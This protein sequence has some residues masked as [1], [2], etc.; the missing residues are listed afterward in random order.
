[1]A[2]G[3]GI[4]LGMMLNPAMLISNAIGDITS[5]I[6]D[7]IKAA[8]EYDSTMK[9]LET[10]TGASAAEVDNMKT[11]VLA[12]APTVA[13]GPEALAK[14][15]YHIESAGIRGSQAIDIMTTAAKGAVVGQADLESVTNAMLAAV[16]SGIGGID[17]MSSAMGVLNAIVGAGNMR[18]ED[19]TAAMSTGILSVAKSF[20]V[21]LESVGGALAD[22]THQGTPAEE[23]ATRLRMTMS[24]MA[25]PTTKAAGALKSIGLNTTDLANAMRGPDGVLGAITML[26]AHLDA[27]GLSA[28]DAAALIVHAFG[29]GKSS[30]GILQLLG[31]VKMLGDTQDRVNKGVGDF[32]AAWAVASDEAT[33]KMANAQAAVDAL[34]IEIGDKLMPVMGDLA[35]GF[36]DLISPPTD[37]ASSVNALADALN[38]LPPPPA[39]TSSW[40]DDTLK[41]IDL[42]GHLANA[43]ALLGDKVYNTAYVLRNEF[44]PTLGGTTDDYIRLAQG[45]DAAGLSI[46]EM[47]TKL[48]GAGPAYASTAGAAH[49]AALAMVKGATD[50]GAAFQAASEIQ[51]QADQK[52]A[53]DA[54][55]AAQKILDTFAQLAPG[56]AKSIRSK[57]NLVKTAMS[58]MMFLITHPAKIAAEKA[59]IAGALTGARLA[60]GLASKNPLIRQ[61]ALD[62]QAQLEADWLALT[63]KAWDAGKA[64]ASAFAG[65]LGRG[66]TWGSPTVHWPKAPGGGRASGGYVPPGWSGSVGEVAQEHLTMFPGGGGMVTAGSGR[67]GGGGTFVYAPQFSP[68][69]EAEARRFAAAIG[70]HIT[71]W[72]RGG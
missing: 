59:K 20:G 39:A 61:V 22:M 38:H 14:S 57:E 46:D 28:T 45:G 65:G 15:L 62:A 64:V 10:Q 55:A 32:P 13:T 43:T 72:Q 5:A 42:T 67:S 68:A 26:K 48:L 6:G 70:P 58:D 49:D 50:T 29:G 36:T 54:S 24:L 11:A 21:S 51:A 17:N 47:R 8:E 66:G 30:A 4:S 31:D 34:K 12:L 41:F 44:Q 37:A 7:S 3:V 56:M 2:K 1:M 35:Q 69:S 33:T 16:N 52:M 40:M 9:L 23:A 18:M 63:G 60:A 71:R 25:A 53:D 19:L 27:S